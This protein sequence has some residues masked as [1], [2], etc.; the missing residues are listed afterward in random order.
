LGEKKFQDQTYE[1]IIAKA[2]RHFLC[3][4]QLRLADLNEPEGKLEFKLSVE[5]DLKIYVIYLTTEPN[6]HTHSQHDY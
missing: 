6:Q 2:D 4:T 1:I 3:Q 5:K